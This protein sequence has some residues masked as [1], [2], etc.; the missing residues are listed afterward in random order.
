M[1]RMKPQGIEAIISS[2]RGAVPKKEDLQQRTSDLSGRRT[3]APTSAPNAQHRVQ[4]AHSLLP[5]L[6]DMSLEELTRRCDELVN[7]NADDLEVGEQAGEQP[8]QE[9]RVQ[10]QTTATDRPPARQDLVPLSRA[11]FGCDPMPATHDVGC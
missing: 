4:E 11:D 10:Q 1:C 8:V 2:R 7:G 6:S 5:G 3:S 9:V